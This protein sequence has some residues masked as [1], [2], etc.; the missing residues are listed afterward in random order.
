MG[1]SKRN[2][3]RNKWGRDIIDKA[4]GLFVKGYAINKIARLPGM[5]RRTDTIH[6][7]K[8][9]DGWVEERELTQVRAKELRI[10]K[11]AEKFSDIDVRQMEQLFDLS[12]EVGK[13][14]GSDYVLTPQDVNYLS[15][16]MDKIIKNERLIS[17]KVTEKQEVG[18]KFGWQDI[19]Y[20]TAKKEKYIVIDM[21]VESSDND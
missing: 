21:P 5:P 18:V 4:R 3:E 15:M 9:R 2:E 11:Y 17:D 19:L 20:A 8:K 12:K 7:W 14:M 1:N 13:V 6:Y 10:E 16:A